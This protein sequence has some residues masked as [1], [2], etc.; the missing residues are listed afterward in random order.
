[1]Q[2]PVAAEK[3]PIATILRSTSSGGEEEP[4][5]L[6]STTVMSLP[7]AAGAPGLS[8][9]ASVLPAGVL[10]TKAT[11]FDNEPSGFCMATER[12]AARARSC[13]LSA[14]VQSAVELQNV[15]RAPPLI[16]T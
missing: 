6:R 12:F 7:V 4:L 15:T 8:G 10:T 2:F 9:I 14:V 13:E 1:M 3:T 11:A 16:I 5:V